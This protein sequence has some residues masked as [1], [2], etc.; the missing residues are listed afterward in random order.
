MIATAIGISTTQL[1]TEM[2]AGKTIAAIATEHNSTAAKVISALVASENSEVDQRVSSGQ[3]TAAQGAQEKTQ[4]TQR[5]TDLVNGTRPDGRTVGRPRR[6]ATERPLGVVNQQLTTHPSPTKPV[7]PRGRLSV[8]LL[9]RL[10]VAGAD[11]LFR[12]RGDP[13]PPRSVQRYAR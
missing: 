5:V 2:T 11:V 10:E 9:R 3:I 6:S 7:L 4:T 13:D 8:G 1:Q 12:C